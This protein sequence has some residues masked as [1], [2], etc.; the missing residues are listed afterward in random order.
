MLFL[1]LPAIAAADTSDPLPLEES[2][3]L[4]LER[5]LLTDDVS[6]RQ[7][8]LSLAAGDNR[9]L[10]SWVVRLAELRTGQTVNRLDQAV[11]WFSTQMSIE[12]AAALYSDQNSSDPEGVEWRLPQLAKKLAKIEQQLLE[13]DPRLEH[14]KLESLK[15][16]AYGASHEI[17]NPLANI[18]ARAQTLL[19]D[20]T[21]PERRKKLIA[22]HRQAIRAHEMISDLML[23]ARP[24]KLNRSPIDLGRLLQ[25][26]VDEL[27]SLAEE[28]SVELRCETALPTTSILADS[29]QLGVALSAVVK[30]ALEATGRGGHVQVGLRRDHDHVEIFVADDGPGISDVARQHMF[31]PFF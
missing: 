1:R 21:N 18:A 3:A 26:I 23:F 6:A 8:E 4:A 2:A 28:S 15:E 11:A 9:A 30:N 27:K 20:E 19:E 31:D 5:A 14:E 16:L 17:N 10:A 22:I 24:P 25:Q 7:Q 29:T 13:F 12:L